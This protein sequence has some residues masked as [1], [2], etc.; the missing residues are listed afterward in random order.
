MASG[1]QHRTISVISH[2]ICPLVVRVRTDQL[3]HVADGRSVGLDAAALGGQGGALSLEGGQ[4]YRPP[5]F[6]HWRGPM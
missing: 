3:G 4:K 2:R 1:S 5:R 6:A